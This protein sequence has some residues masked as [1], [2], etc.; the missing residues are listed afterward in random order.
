MNT[1]K[2]TC[3]FCST[4]FDY[5]PIVGMPFT[6]KPTVCDECDALR[7]TAEESAMMK[8]RMAEFDLICPPAYR[9]SDPGHPSMPS[10]SKLA[11]ILNWKPNPIGLVI[12]GDT[13]TCKT[14]CS[15]MLVKSLVVQ[16]GVG[17]HYV[18]SNEFAAESAS[19]WSSSEWMTEL[20]SAPV[21]FVD[22]LFKHRPSERVEA[23][24]FQLLDTRIAKQLPNII[25]TNFVGDKILQQLSKDRGPA[26]V[27]RIREFHKSV[28]LHKKP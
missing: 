3:Q 16:Q 4:E 1:E 27:E 9:E 8:K 13:R 26:I 24:L 5:E 22:D 10:P 6:L 11:E 12:H 21:L 19:A 20:L 17:V 18:S 2:T 15:W 14:R 7:R 25:T 28:S 23:D